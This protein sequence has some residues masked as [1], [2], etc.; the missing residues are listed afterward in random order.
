MRLSF[1]TNH[2]RK[3]KWGYRSVAEHW[4][5]RHEA[6]GLIP[7]HKLKS[8]KREDLNPE[9]IRDVAG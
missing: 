3:R 2:E 5:C 6:L 8:R 4:L 9:T 7:S 1:K